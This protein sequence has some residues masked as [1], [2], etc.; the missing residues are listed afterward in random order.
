MLPFTRKEGSSIYT[1]TI[2][3]TQIRRGVAAK[4]QTG[5]GQRLPILLRLVIG[6]SH[7]F[8][9]DPKVLDQVLKTMNPGNNKSAKPP[10]DGSTSPNSDYL[11]LVPGRN[12]EVQFVTYSGDPEKKYVKEFEL[13]LERGSAPSLTVYMKDPLA[14]IQP[15]PTTEIPGQQLLTL[16]G[17]LVYTC[18]PIQVPP[19]PRKIYIYG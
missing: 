9:P 10:H 13:S 5:Q 18:R 8:E 6:D 15:K 16:I 3:V 1:D 14:E 11:L 7:T 2:E 19:S 17:E 4:I 12:P